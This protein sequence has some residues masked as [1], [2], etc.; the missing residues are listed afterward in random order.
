[1]YAHTLTNSSVR[2]APANPESK[3]RAWKNAGSTAMRAGITYVEVKSAMTP[4]KNPRIAT[5][6]KILNLSLIQFTLLSS[7]HLQPLFR[8]TYTFM[9]ITQRLGTQPFNV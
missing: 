1:M 8:L 5:N 7:I 2:Q 6:T 4:A 9:S 3:Y